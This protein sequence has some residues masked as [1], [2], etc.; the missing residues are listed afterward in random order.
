MI[1]LLYRPY[2]VTHY[3]NSVFQRVLSLA[4]Q[5]SNTRAIR[6][7]ANGDSTVISLID[8]IGYVKR[9][10]FVNIKFPSCAQSDKCLKNQTFF[11]TWF[12]GWSVEIRCT[13]RR[14]WHT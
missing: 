7:S 12:R 9:N 11:I 10:I 5:R 4:L 6:G 14:R 2:G 8:F 3:A 1:K 13:P